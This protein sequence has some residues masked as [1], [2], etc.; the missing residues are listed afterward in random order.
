MY[1]QFS[2]KMCFSQIPW[3]TYWLEN[4]ET[5]TLKTVLENIYILQNTHLPLDGY[6]P[7][8]KICYFFVLPSVTICLRVSFSYLKKIKGTLKTKWGAFMEGDC[9][10]C[11][12]L[13]VANGAWRACFPLHRSDLDT[14]WQAYLPDRDA[15]RWPP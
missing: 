5:F 3:Y 6:K 4:N 15:W 2:V 7:Q 8:R 9:G 14:R 13:S 10:R 1:F 12:S 11:H